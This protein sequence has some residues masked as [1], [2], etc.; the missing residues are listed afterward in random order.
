MVAPWEILVQL[1]VVESLELFQLQLLH[2]FWQGLG[3]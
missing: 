3:Y 1:M 2:A